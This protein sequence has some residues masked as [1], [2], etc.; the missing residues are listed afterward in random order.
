MSVAAA[1]I[2]NDINIETGIPEPTINEDLIPRASIVI[3][4][5]NIVASRI[6]P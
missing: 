4:I 3:S 2:N 5:T 1:M 6:L